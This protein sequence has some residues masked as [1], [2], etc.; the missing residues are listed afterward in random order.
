MLL[1]HI[2]M[3]GYLPL[4]RTRQDKNKESINECG[5]NCTMKFQGLGKSACGYSVISI[6]SSQIIDYL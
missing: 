6:Y 2:P 4:V 5:S 1:G 3:F